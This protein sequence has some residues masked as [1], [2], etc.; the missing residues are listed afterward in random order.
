MTN[1]SLISIEERRKLG[2]KFLAYIP[3]YLLVPIMFAYLFNQIGFA[4]SWLS[5][6][7]G[8]LGWIIALIVRTPFILLLQKYQSDQSQRFIPWL[9]GP[10]E[11]ITRYVLLFLTATS[12]TWALSFGQ[13]WAAIE[14]LYVIGNSIAI[15]QLLHREDPEAKQAKQLLGE[16]GFLNYHHPLIGVIE[17]ISASAYHIGATIMIFQYP[18]LV[19]PFIILHSVLNVVSLYLS[20]KNSIIWSELWIGVI[21]FG[22]LG[23]GLYLV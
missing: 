2:K 4:F 10:T 17:R 7:L 8:A 21:G 19:I 5:L 20:K 12:S 15:L 3:V 14:V 6:G 13:G 23:L 22:V 11:E 9:S 18:I 1:L 16:M